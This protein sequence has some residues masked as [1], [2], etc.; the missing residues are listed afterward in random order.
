MSYHTERKRYDYLK[1]LAEQHLQQGIY[2]GSIKVGSKEY[3]EICETIEH[4]DELAS[5]YQTAY[6]ENN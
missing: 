2:D 4:Y 5:R 1:S 6:E 3:H